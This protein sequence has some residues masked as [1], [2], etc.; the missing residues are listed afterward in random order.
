MLQEKRYTAKEWEI[1]MKE[2]NK[3]IIERKDLVK[4]GFLMIGQLFKS[5]LEENNKIFS[6]TAWKFLNSEPYVDCKVYIEYLDR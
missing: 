4:P 3:T 1:L 6:V 2:L 5:I